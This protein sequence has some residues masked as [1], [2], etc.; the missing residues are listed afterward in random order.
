[1]TR[2]PLWS[3]LALVALF[4]TAFGVVEGSVVVYLR[5]LYY[6]G[7][8][9]FPLL[10]LE[11]QY[12]RVEVAREAATILMLVAFAMV[13]VRG[14]WERFAVFMI[15]FGIWDIVYYAWLAIVLG[16]PASLIEWDVLFLIPLPW[17]GPVVAPVTVAMLMVWAG[18]L[19]LAR[20]AKGWIF[21]PGRA[22]WTLGGGATVL[23]LWTFMSDTAATIGGA[24]PAPFRYE[25][26]L[27]GCAGLVIVFLRS[28]QAPTHSR[29]A[30][31]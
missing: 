21:L 17:I 9:E 2:S 18:I 22:G 8:F 29:P 20:R 25:L 10:P 3:L 5:A 6:P 31:S 13:S 30:A 14:R 28:F 23:I 4:G 7:G 27:A 15:S 11:A 16:W 1:V 24:L 12:I 19:L 26:F